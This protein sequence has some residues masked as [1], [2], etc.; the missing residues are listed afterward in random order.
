MVKTVVK[1]EFVIN[2]YLIQDSF[3]FTPGQE[4]IYNSLQRKT[5]SGHK[6]KKGHVHIS[7]FSQLRQHNQLKQ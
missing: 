5:S 6:K 1:E 7:I 4:F 2:I 3:L